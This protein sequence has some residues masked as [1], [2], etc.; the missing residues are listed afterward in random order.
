MIYRIGLRISNDTLAHRED[1]DHPGQHRFIMYT[2]FVRPL[3]GFAES[4]SKIECIWA[5]TRENVPSDKIFDIK[6]TS[7][8]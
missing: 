7:L 2:I 5:T 4:N 8:I 3:P 6:E 1:S